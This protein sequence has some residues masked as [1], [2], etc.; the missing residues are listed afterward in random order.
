MPG[1]VI[2]VRH[3]TAEVLPDQ[4][5]GSWPLSAAGRV[6]AADLKGRFP[7][8]AVLASGGELKAID[9]ISLAAAV[10]PTSIH[11]DDDFGEVCRPGELFDNDHRPRRRAWVE[12]RL[13]SRHE[14]WETPEQAGHRFQRGLDRLDVELDVDIAAVATHGMV[15]TAW[16]VAIGR[17]Q[18]GV[19]AGDFWDGLSFP[20]VL[21]IKP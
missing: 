9:T 6:A 4:A 5:S 13:D 10:E 17:V 7:R 3:A 15:L 11:I 2:I 12:G 21:T 19:A 16:L 14:S 1:T 20:D 18:R 8:G